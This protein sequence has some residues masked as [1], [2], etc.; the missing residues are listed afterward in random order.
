[1]VERVRFRT[2][3]VA[4]IALASLLVLVVY[5][6]TTASRKAEEIYSRLDQVNTHHRE[7]EAKLRRLRSDVHLSGIFVRDYL[8]DTEREHADDYQ[9]QL[10]EYRRANLATLAELRVLAAD[11]E[12]GRIANL[13]SQLE[14]YWRAFEPLI[15]W[16]IAEKITLSARF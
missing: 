15:G 8:L 16:T 3:P 14:D 1:M 11:D 10:A 13:Q 5:T 4:A 2:W 7:V 12:A 9:Q 6:V